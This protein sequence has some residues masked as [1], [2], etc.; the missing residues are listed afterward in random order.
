MLTV[1]VLTFTPLEIVVK[2]VTRWGRN[3]GGR[4]WTRTSCY[5]G[6]GWDT[7]VTV[8]VLVHVSPVVGVW[9]I[10]GWGTVM[11]TD[12]FGR[13]PLVTGTTVVTTTL[14]GVL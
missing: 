11:T 12:V 9:M 7:V 8:V 14:V 13:A 3:Y 4:V 5:R 6:E 1:T 2:V 10:K